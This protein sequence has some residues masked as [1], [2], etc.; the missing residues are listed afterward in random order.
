ME[1]VSCASHHPLLFRR[2]SRYRYSPYSVPPIRTS[3]HH[4]PPP[5]P[6]LTPV[7]YH[8]QPSSLYQ[9]QQ[10]PASLYQ[11][12]QP[13]F[14]YIFTPETPLFHQSSSCLSLPISYQQGGPFVT[15]NT[16][17]SVA[18]RRS[19]IG[20]IIRD[21]SG[22]PLLAFAA[23]C[24]KMPIYAVELCAIK[25]GLQL[26]LANG[27][28]YVNIDTDSTDAVKW[29]FSL[30]SSCPLLVRKCVFDIHL[31]LSSFI[32]WHVKHVYR[33]TNSAADFLSKFAQN[34]ELVLH[35]MHFPPELRYIVDEDAKG[36][37]YLRLKSVGL[38]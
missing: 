32:S 27:V 6:P 31:L 3:I 13:S 21:S 22:F 36:R 29:I 34:A 10:Q 19:G 1:N 5:P 2:V 37:L 26:A 24:P 17:G 33:E 15:L 11:Q 4:L 25:R 8:Q 18:K 35:P 38:R 9:Q 28:Q 30:P 12:Q 16:D 7:P 23:R 14:P 20:G